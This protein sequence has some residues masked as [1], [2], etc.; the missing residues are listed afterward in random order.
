LVQRAAQGRQAFM[1]QIERPASLILAA[2]IAFGL[3][4]AAVL[5]WALK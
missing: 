2:L 5:L 1:R 4:S 3:L